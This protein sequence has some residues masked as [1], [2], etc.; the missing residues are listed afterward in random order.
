MCGEVSDAW[1]GQQGAA[2]ASADAELWQ[3]LG[4][5]E[6]TPSRPQLAAGRAA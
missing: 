1:Q 4:L 5:A 3:Q 2:S 6:L